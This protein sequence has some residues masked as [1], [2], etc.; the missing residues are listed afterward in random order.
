MQCCNIILNKLLIAGSA[1]SKAGIRREWDKTQKDLPQDKTPSA[2][3]VEW[4]NT[5]AP[6]PDPRAKAKGKA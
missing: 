5:V 1:K 3:V 2:V 4:L 6:P